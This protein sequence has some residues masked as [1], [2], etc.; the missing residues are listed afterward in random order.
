MKMKSEKERERNCSKKSGDKNV[1]KI[2]IKVK[3]TLK[4]QNGAFTFIGI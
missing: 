1:F 4:P 2:I 3:K